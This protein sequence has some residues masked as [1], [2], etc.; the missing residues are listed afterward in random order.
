MSTRQGGSNKYPQC[1]FVSTNKKNIVYPCKPQFYY[2]KVGFKWV[3]IIYACF[4]DETFFMLTSADHE[5]R[6]ANKSQ[7]TNNC[8]FFLA[9]HK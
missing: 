4:R 5:L 9:K 6:S 3:N 2:I 1:M 8:K 7:D